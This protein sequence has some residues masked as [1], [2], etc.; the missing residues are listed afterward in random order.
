MRMASVAGAG[1]M[2]TGVL[3]VCGD[4]ALEAGSPALAPVAVWCEEHPEAQRVRV[5]SSELGSWGSGLVSCLLAV[6]ELCARHGVELETDGL[7]SD[8]P[9]LLELGTAQAASVPAPSEEPA[10]RAISRLGLWAIAW[11]GALREWVVANG[12][13]RRRNAGNGDA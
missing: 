9:G 5:E 10:M 2:R 1:G 6:R 12:A 13:I 4:W 3:R 11:R 8:L 7:S